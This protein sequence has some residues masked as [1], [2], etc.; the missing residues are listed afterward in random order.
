MK[1]LS[2]AC[3]GETHT[4]IY[5]MM[6]RASNLWETM[7]IVIDIHQ[8]IFLPGSSAKYT[9]TQHIFQNIFSNLAGCARVLMF[10]AHEIFMA[11]R[12][13][14]P[15]CIHLK[16]FDTTAWLIDWVG[17]I[18]NPRSP[19]TPKHIAMCAICRVRES[20]STSCEKGEKETQ[21]RRWSTSI[22]IF[23]LYELAAALCVERARE[24]KEK[25]ELGRLI[26]RYSSFCSGTDAN[27][28]EPRSSKVGRITVP[29]NW[30]T[31]PLIIYFSLWDQGTYMFRQRLKDSIILFVIINKV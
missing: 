7:G 24:W 6:Q 17:G 27:N 29:H 8:T 11:L 30:S 3:A 9:N 15:Y 16:E 2:W 19:S 18:R 5:E 14:I 31:V 10:W 23:L 20:E 12:F 21:L 25:C 13:S 28:I 1:L 26:W 4:K 22:Y